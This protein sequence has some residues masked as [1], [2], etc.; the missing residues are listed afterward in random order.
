MSLVIATTVEQA[1][2]ELAGGARPIAG[3]TDL[4][5]AHRQGRAQLPASLVAIDRLV[6]L[7]AVEPLDG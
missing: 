6:E 1:L 5:V 3:G 2:A 7:Q 4:V